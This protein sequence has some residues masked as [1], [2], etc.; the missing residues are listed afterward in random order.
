M[1]NG[2]DPTDSQEWLDAFDSVLKIKG[3]EQ[4]YTLLDEL[5]SA[6]RRRGVPVP[7][8]ATTP[9]LNTIPSDRQQPYPGDHAVENRIRSMVRWNALAMVLRANKDSTELGGH[10]AS[11]LS[12]AALWEVGFHHFWHAAGDGHGGTWSSYRATPRRVS[13]RMRSW[14]VGCP[15][16]TC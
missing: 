4:A 9:Y 1:T 12:A 16:S 2:L 5:L 10:I 11:F 6:A 8:S 3:P 7:Y 14:R 15:R 13:T